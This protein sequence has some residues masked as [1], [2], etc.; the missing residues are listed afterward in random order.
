MGSGFRLELLQETRFITDGTRIRRGD[1][2]GFL[3]IKWEGL[4]LPKDPEFGGS[5]PIR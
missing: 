3:T 1:T 4:C 5:R 2:T